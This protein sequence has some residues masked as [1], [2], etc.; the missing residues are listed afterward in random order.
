MALRKAMRACELARADWLK[1]YRPTSIQS[2]VA[3]KIGNFFDSLPAPR[4]DMQRDNTKTQL[5]RSP[6]DPTR[7]QHEPLEGDLFRA[8]FYQ[9]EDKNF[10]WRVNREGNVFIWLMDCIGSTVEFIIICAEGKPT[11]GP[12]FLDTKSLFD[13]DR[14]TLK[15]LLK[16]LKEN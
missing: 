1:D 8:D 5:P 12:A 14:E 13:T 10:R 7:F 4:E 9:E 2:E 15:N 16:Y 3:A 11:L 6:L